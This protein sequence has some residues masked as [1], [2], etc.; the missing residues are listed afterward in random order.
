[1]A[2]FIV[3][4]TRTHFYTVEIEAEDWHAAKEEIDEW[5]SDDFENYATNAQ[6]DIDINEI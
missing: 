6:W 1:M 5:T 2:R 3:N 4:A